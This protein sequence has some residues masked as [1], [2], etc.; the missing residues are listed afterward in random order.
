VL[1][2]IVAGYA[3]AT[4]E[5]MWASGLPFNDDECSN[6][7]CNNAGSKRCQTCKRVRYCGRRCQ[8]AHWKAHKED[9]KR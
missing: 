6:P 7:A 2:P 1:Q 4:H 3:T 9:C 8:Q 5:D